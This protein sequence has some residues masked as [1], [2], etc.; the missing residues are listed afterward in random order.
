[1]G[2]VQVFLKAIR[3]HKYENI[4]ALAT[5]T[6][7]RQGELFGLAWDAVDLAKG[8]M[9]IRQTLEWRKEGGWTLSECKTD[10]SHRTLYLPQIGLN[11]LI[12]QKLKQSEAR[13]KAGSW[14]EDNNLVFTNEFGRPLTNSGVLDALHNLLDKAALRR[15]RFHDLRHLAAS[16]QLAQGASLREVMEQLG[17]STITLTANTYTHLQEAMKAKAAARMDAALTFAD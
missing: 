9:T 12:A 16:L 10:R 13:T 15:Q 5:A 8:T 1:M 2:E 11:A 3:G 17:H 14:W 7:A 6:G 4:Y